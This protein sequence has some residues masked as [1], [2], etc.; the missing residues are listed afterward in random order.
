MGYVKGT[1]TFMGIISF[2]YG[3]RMGIGLKHLILVPFLY[4]GYH[5]IF[6]GNG[7]QC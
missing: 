7:F 2:I 1:L 3:Y 4:T 5:F 6:L